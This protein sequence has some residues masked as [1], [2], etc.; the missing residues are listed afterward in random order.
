MLVPELSTELKAIKDL[1]CLQNWI[2]YSIDLSVQ[3]SVLSCPNPAICYE[4]KLHSKY[5]YAVS[6]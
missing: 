1:N 4:I 3:Q 5:K 2:S 6:N